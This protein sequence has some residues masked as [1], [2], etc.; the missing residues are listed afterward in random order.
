MVGNLWT[1]HPID[2]SEKFIITI[3]SLLKTKH[4]KP[5]ICEVVGNF[6]KRKMT[7]PTFSFINEVMSLLHNDHVMSKVN[8]MHGYNTTTGKTNG[9]V[10][11]HPESLQH[12]DS[13]AV[14]TPI[15]KTRKLGEVTNGYL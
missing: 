4:H 2:S 3:S 15:D 1:E 8:K 7:I 5:S 10:F 6:D 13:S 11:W 14:P 12:L 9:H